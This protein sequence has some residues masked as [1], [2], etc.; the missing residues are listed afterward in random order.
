[1]PVLVG[2]MGDYDRWKTDPEWGRRYDDDFEEGEDEPDKECI[3][4]ECL[5]CGE[6]YRYECFTA[7]DCEDQMAEAGDEYFAA[8]RDARLTIEIG[9]E[10]L[11]DTV[12]REILDMFQRGREAIG[13]PRYRCPECGYESCRAS[14]CDGLPF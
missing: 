8:I 11:R 1:M 7:E 5:F 13:L 12:H 6:H 3:G 14:D 9:I 10:R 2:Q 4:E